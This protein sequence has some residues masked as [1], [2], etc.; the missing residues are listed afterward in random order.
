MIREKAEYVAFPKHVLDKHVQANTLNP[1]HL[2]NGVAPSGDQHFLGSIL[3]IRDACDVVNIEVSMNELVAR[4]PVAGVSR[5][6]R[7]A[8]ASTSL[9][10]LQ[11]AAK[12]PEAMTGI[13]NLSSAGTRPFSTG[14]LNAIWGFCSA[15]EK[16]LAV[17]Q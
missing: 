3:K 12:F 1:L 14:L 11:T 6:K 15:S 7:T 13:P 10:I 8:N 2:N 17:G 16:S 5:K 9:P 4:L